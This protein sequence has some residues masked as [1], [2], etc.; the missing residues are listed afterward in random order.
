M[1]RD[2]L[3]WHGSLTNL[4]NLLSIVAHGNGLWVAYGGNRELFV[5]RDG[6]RWVPAAV[7]EGNPRLAHIVHGNGRFLAFPEDGNRIYTS[8][9]GLRWSARTPRSRS[10]DELEWQ[11]RTVENLDELGPVIFLNKRFFGLG[12]NGLLMSSRDGVT[13]Q[14][15][16][17]PT[18]RWLSTMAFGHHRYLAG[19][20]NVL[21]RS[22]D[23][24]HWDVDAVPYA[25][26]DIAFV[27]GW[28]VMVGNFSGALISRDGMEWHAMTAP[29]EGYGSQLSVAGDALVMVSPWNIYRGTFE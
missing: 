20:E 17:I 12:A 10:R 24:T 8:A 28:F 16:E 18:T 9:S 26:H 15:H 25:I 3:A 4:D 23:A 21:A 14:R 2:G 29:A 1:S 5:S 7:P 11:E 27:N 19:G 6:L 22:I 13:W